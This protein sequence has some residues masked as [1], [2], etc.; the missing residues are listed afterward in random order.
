MARALKKTGATHIAWAADPDLQNAEVQD[1]ESDLIETLNPRANV[2]HPVPPV[3][4]QKHTQ[5]II[6]EFRSLIHKNRS[7][8]FAVPDLQVD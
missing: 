5:K 7:D 8:R 3:N 4:L 2:S 1:I 6:G